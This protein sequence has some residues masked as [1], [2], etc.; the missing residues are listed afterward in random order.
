MS[1]GPLTIT[2]LED[3]IQFCATIQPRASKNEICGPQ[4]NK[5]KIRLTSPP[6]DGAANRMCVKFLAKTLRV[7]PSSITIV[8]GLKGRNKVI[9]INAM[10]ENTFFKMILPENKP[11][12][13]G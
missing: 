1:Q 8:S 3:G 7:P 13:K 6:V 11:N 5:L 9:R 4:D 10:D 12:R 2:T